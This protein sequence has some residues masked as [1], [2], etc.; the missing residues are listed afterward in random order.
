MTTLNDATA[1][2][3]IFVVIVLGLNP[4]FHFFSWRVSSES[5]TDRARCPSCGRSGGENSG[6]QLIGI[7]QKSEERY[8]PGLR[9]GSYGE[10]MARHEKY[11][12][13]YKC[14]YCGHEWTSYKILR[15]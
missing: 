14:K 2:L 6:D 9:R 4:I 12:V 3:L 8:Y 15:Q 13:Q 11:K 10:K 7:F 1:A 5:L